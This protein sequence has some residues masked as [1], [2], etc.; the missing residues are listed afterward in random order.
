[1][2]FF[3]DACKQ[4]LG[5]WF[6]QQVDQTTAW[7]LPPEFVWKRVSARS[8]LEVLKDSAHRRSI[9]VSGCVFEI[10]KIGDVS[11][12]LKKKKWVLGMALSN[13]GFMCCRAG[14]RVLEHP[15]GERISPTTGTNLAASLQL[16]FL[17]WNSD[18]KASRGVCSEERSVLIRRQDS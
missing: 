11:I 5:S 4:R 18:L 2:G 15:L 14:G 17:M 1:M 13:Y 9:G 3:L 7:F 10:S 12:R 6:L 16:P 8:P